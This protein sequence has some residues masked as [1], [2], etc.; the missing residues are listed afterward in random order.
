M[1]TNVDIMYVKDRVEPL[2]LRISFSIATTDLQEVPLKL[3]AQAM[4]HG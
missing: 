4:G 3:M 2:L 1:S